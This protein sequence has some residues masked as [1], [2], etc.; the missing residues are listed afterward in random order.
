MLDT[1]LYGQIH[2][3]W[4]FV[5]AFVGFLAASLCRMAKLGGDYYPDIEDAE[6]LYQPRSLKT[7]AEK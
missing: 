1:I 3:V 5:A 2:W 4:V 7:R 6:H